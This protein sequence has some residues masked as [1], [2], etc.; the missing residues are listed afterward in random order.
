VKRQKEKGEG[1]LGCVCVCSKNCIGL[2]K[3]GRIRVRVLWGG[4]G[5][6]VGVWV[7]W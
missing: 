6:C 4:V 3:G 7:L 5:G 1:V 2:I